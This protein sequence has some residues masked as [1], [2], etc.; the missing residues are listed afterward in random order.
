MKIRETMRSL[1]ENHES[2]LTFTKPNG[3]LDTRGLYEN[4]R[5]RN[6]KLS[7]C[8]VVWHGVRARKWSFRLWLAIRGRLPTRERMHSWGLV[9]TDIFPL[10]GDGVESV[11]HLWGTCT[12]T[13]QVMDRIWSW[14]GV[15]ARKANLLEWMAW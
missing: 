7:W 1:M 8:E 4:I 5:K 13:L 3:N 12:F 15:Y 6:P 11:E 9:A 14:V 10:C 2:S